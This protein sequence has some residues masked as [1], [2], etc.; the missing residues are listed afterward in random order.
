M[1]IYVSATD[2]L[3]EVKA[4]MPYFWSGLGLVWAQRSGIVP[5]AIEAGQTPIHT[6]FEV[7]SCFRRCG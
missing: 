5:E 4:V 6:L 7:D 2:L 1:E 3:G